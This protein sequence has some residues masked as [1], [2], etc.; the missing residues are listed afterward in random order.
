MCEKSLKK[1]KKEL[2][3]IYFKRKDF[4]FTIDKT[5]YIHKHGLFIHII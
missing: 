2:L 5:K 1:V 4:I 3:K